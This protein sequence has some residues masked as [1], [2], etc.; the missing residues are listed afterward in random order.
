[1]PMA[2]RRNA[3]EANALSRRALD[4]FAQRSHIGNGLFAVGALNDLTYRGHQ[5]R[6]R[7]ARP[8]HQVFRSVEGVPTVL[9]VGQKYRGSLG[10]SRPRTRMSPTSRRF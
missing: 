10:L 7:S 5:R 3:I 1:M 6:R 8:N 9:H 4:N 2:A